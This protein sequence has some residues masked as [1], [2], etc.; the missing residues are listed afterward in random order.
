MSKMPW[1]YC[2]TLPDYNDVELLESELWHLIRSHRRR[3]GDSLVLF[4]G[5][6][7]IAIAKIRQLERRPIRAAIEIKERR[8][9]PMPS[10]TIH[11]ASALPKGIDRDY[12]LT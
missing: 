11:L 2:P 7:K 6:G 1:L 9:F 8:A 5:K 4:D 10:P 3:V 12:C